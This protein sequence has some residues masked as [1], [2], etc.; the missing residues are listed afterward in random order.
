[1]LLFDDEDEQ[2]YPS[3]NIVQGTSV[4]NGFGVAVPLPYCYDPKYY[5]LLGNIRG[6]E[7]PALVVLIPLSNWFDNPY[8][9]YGFALA[10]ENKWGYWN[11][12]KELYEKTG[13]LTW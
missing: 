7:V 12:S 11:H 6:E 8:K 9:Q 4:R 13:E 10:V 5:L 1:M 3:G 2:Y